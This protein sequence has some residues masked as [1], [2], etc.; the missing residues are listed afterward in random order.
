ME[1]DIAL[2]SKGARLRIEA[3]A[4]PRTGGE[5]TGEIRIEGDLKGRRQLTAPTCPG[6]ARALVLV[7]RLA[8]LERQLGEA[9]PPPPVSPPPK[10]PAPVTPPP[11]EEAPPQEEREGALGLG[12]ALGY[13]AGIGPLPG[14]AQGPTLGLEG[15]LHSLE[16]NLQLGWLMPVSP[17][18]PAG[19]KLSV[20]A[21]T[22][23]L[24]ACWRYSDAFWL[25]A[26]C[27]A[28]GLTW[29]HG[30]P[31]GALLEQQIRDLWF[32]RAGLGLRFRLLAHEPGLFLDGRLE[33][34]LTRP[35]MTVEGWGEAHRPDAV[36]GWLGVTLAWGN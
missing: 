26:P 25:P 31:G 30:E 18:L 15:H 27:L 21:G 5:W 19:A 3:W 14:L 29:I 1:R 4:K 6:L 20:Q 8:V 28:L 24:A 11:V 10:P 22:A 36:G 33:A 23:E 7:V 34:P 17:S 2:V 35:G 12:P 9:K 16:A 32:L 13:R